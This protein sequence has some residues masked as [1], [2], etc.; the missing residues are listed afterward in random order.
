MY[1]LQ[2]YQINTQRSGEILRRWLAEKHISQASAAQRMGITEDT[3]A[4][5][6]RGNVKQPSLTYVFK[7][8]I[9][10]GH[11][12]EEY[13]HLVL[14]DD[15]IEFAADIRWTDAPEQV[16]P[17]QTRPAHG[18][19]SDIGKMLDR[20]SAH[21]ETEIKLLENEHRKAEQHMEQ[22]IE[23]LERRCNRL[24]IALIA[25]NIAVVGVL[26]VSVMHLA[27]DWLQSAATRIFSLKS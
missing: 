6:L 23:K 17:E 10:T 24:T 19:S 9:M 7:L 14:A 1:S 13:L 2:N 25:E 27:T 16:Q 4:G 5:C 26:A 12:M 22:E 20:M 15:P 11:T 8:C 18:N 21:Y 3:L